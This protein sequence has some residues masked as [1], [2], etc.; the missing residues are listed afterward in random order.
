MKSLNLNLHPIPLHGNKIFWNLPARSGLSN[1]MG[2]PSRIPK[3]TSTQHSYLLVE[4]S[5]N[6]M[7]TLILKGRHVS[8]LGFL[9]PNIKFVQYVERAKDN[10]DIDY[11]LLTDHDLG[12]NTPFLCLSTPFSFLNV[13]HVMRKYI[14]NQPI[15]CKPFRKIISFSSRSCKY[16]RSFNGLFR[17][18]CNRM[19]CNFRL[20]SIDNLKMSKMFKRYNYYYFEV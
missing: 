2:S 20:N 15:N 17:S 5:E 18:F 7:D 13:H 11:R 19:F 8:V 14:K 16:F 4:P 9:R 6:K 10:H 1:V 12:I 3:F